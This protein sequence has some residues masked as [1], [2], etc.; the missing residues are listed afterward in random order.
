MAPRSPAGAP[1]DDV[2]R[3][4]VRRA[5]PIAV[6]AAAGIVVLL[7]AGDSTALNAVALF[8]LGV[9]AV[10]VVALFFYEIGLGEDRDRAKGWQ[11]PYDL[12]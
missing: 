10:L 4:R 3:A 6:L 1:E 12:P 11:G 9:A 8:V 7:V 2:R 5:I